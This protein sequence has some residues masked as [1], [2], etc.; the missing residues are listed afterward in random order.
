[1]KGELLLVKAFS[2]QEV[3]LGV[4][5]G[6]FDEEEDDFDVVA[7]VA[8]VS[9]V[10]LLPLTALLLSLVGGTGLVLLLS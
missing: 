6:G 4:G 7:G 8:G 1:M 3:Y 5:E 2:V 9:E 10:L